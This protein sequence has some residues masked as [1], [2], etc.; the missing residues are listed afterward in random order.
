MTSEPRFTRQITDAC[1]ITCQHIELPSEFTSRVAAALFV[2]PRRCVVLTAS[3]DITWT[4][5]ALTVLAHRVAGRCP[6]DFSALPEP[7]G[8]QFAQAVAMVLDWCEVAA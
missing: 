5:D 6:L 7:L 1:G 2:V 4:P 8:E 3:A